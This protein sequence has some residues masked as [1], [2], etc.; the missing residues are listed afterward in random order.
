MFAYQMSLSRLHIETYT[1]GKDPMSTVSYFYHVMVVMI[2]HNWTDSIGLSVSI[3][4]V[5]REYKLVMQ[6]I[7]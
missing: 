1:F 2:C 3:V 7:S 4:N 5:S 6:C